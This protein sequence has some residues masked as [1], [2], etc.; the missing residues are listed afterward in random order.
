MKNGINTSSALHAHTHPDLVNRGFMTCF[1]RNVFLSI[2]VYIS[3]LAP[4]NTLVSFQRALQMD[5]TGLEA[6]VAIR[7][8][9]THTHTHAHAHTHR[10]MEQ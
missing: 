6:D 7:Y 3:Q 4:E 1:E 10:S 8:T 2:F 9:H 5:V